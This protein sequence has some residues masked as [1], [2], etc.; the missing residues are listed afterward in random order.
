VGK[1]TGLGL[2]TVYGVVKQ[3]AGMVNVYSEVDHGTTFKVYWPLVT[4]TAKPAPE[5]ETITDGRG[6]ET[7]LVAEDDEGVLG[8]VTDL[9]TK[10]GYHVLPAKD[11]QHAIDIFNRDNPTV[12]LALLDV[13]M[14]NKSGREVMDHIR[15]SGS[16]IPIVFASGYSM[17][18]IHTDFVL[19]EGIVLLEK[20]YRRQELLS[21]LRQALQ[22]G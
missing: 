11:G 2:S 7:I 10:N 9:L 4:G 15:Q 1:G 3:N 16:D 20:P 17:N 19:D 12:D 21:R 18:A 13:I 14:P 6:Q 22:T 5:T 8:F